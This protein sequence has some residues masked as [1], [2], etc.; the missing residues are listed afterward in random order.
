MR[1][2]RVWE[3]GQYGAGVRRHPRGKLLGP[4]LP[5]ELTPINRAAAWDEFG[6]TWTKG[7]WSLKGLN[8]WVTSI[9]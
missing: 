6:L 1:A 2:G 7:D 4:A 5:G 3:V 8:D 9:Q